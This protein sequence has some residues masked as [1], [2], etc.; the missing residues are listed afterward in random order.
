VLAYHK[1]D[2]RFELGVNSVTPAR[3]ARHLSTLLDLGMRAVDL[4]TLLDSVGE[5]PRSGPPR[6]HLTFDD[7]Y[8]N[9]LDHAWPV[10]RAHGFPATVF[11][12]AAYVGRENT[13]DISFPRTRHLSWSDLRELSDAGVSIGA[14][15]DTHPF[16]TRIAFARARQ[17][18]RDSRRRL[19]DGLG[20]P[21][22]VFAY[23]H[24]DSSA[25]VRSLVEDAGY[26]AAFSLDPGAQFGEAERWRLPRTGVYAVDGPRAVA[27]KVGARGPRA[28]H[29]AWAVNRLFRRCG[30]AGQLVPRRTER[31]DPRA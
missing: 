1:V 27:A 24:G 21:V 15:T 28:M 7:G 6:V 31:S 17:E 16:L 22:R 30:Y 18:I 5:R 29:R 23:P 19:E 9:F 8:R 11:P 14:H 13:W 3:F 12:V 26:E 2:T 10:C 25:A 4:P 20:V